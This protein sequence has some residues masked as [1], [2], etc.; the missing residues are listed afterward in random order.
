MASDRADKRRFTN[1]RAATLI[2]V[3]LYKVF[4]LRVDTN[5]SFASRRQFSGRGPFRAL[6][7]IRK[8]FN[9]MSIENLS[10]I[11]ETFIWPLAKYGS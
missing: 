11:Y 8:Y 1:N 4:G 3:D 6:T 10:T 2:T 9:F 5:S 7:L